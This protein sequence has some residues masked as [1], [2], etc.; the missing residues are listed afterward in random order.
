MF[1]SFFVHFNKNVFATS[2]AFKFHSTLFIYLGI[3]IKAIL[4][5]IICI[6]RSKNLKKYCFHAQGSAF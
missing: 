1:H 4:S 3:Y 2:F 6:E 5:F